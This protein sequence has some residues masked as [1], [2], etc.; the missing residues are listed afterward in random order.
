MIINNINDMM[1]IIPKTKSML[2]CTCTS[3]HYP[4]YLNRVNVWLEQIKKLN[5]DSDLFVFNDGKCL[6]NNELYNNEN[7]IFIE[8][9]K[10]LGRKSIWVFPG[11]IRSFYYALLLST[12]YQYFSHIENDVLIKH[13]EVFCNNYKKNNIVA[14]PYNY[15]YKFPESSL[16]IINDVS[17]REQLFHKFN[18]DT[19]NL[20]VNFENRFESCINSYVNIGESYRHEGSYVCQDP[21]IECQCS[22]EYILQNISK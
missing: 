12:K 13:V 14:F 22:Y 19:W 4:F 3:L 20:N 9:E 10:A 2:Y 8:F 21:V 11:W 6:G 17:V 18:P 5:I 7:I 1:N 16:M 15:Q